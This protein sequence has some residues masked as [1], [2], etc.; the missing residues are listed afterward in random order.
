[1]KSDLIH[2]DG[3]SNWTSGINSKKAALKAS[4]KVRGS[5]SPASGAIAVKL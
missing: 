4:D 2:Q 5:P 3:S 1:M